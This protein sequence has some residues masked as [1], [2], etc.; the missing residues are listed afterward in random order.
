MVFQSGQT[1]KTHL[2]FISFSTIINGLSGSLHKGKEHVWWAIETCGMQACRAIYGASVARALL[3]L[4][5]HAGAFGA[6][7]TLGDPAGLRS[8]SGDFG[9]PGLA[10]RAGSGGAGADGSVP[11]GEGVSAADTTSAPGAPDVGA[12]SAH[13]DGCSTDEGP[14]FMAKVCA[15]MHLSKQLCPTTSVKGAVGSRPTGISTLVLS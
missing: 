2:L 4:A 15:Q 1:T 13:G 5:V 3:P 14:Q 12:S 7:Q 6:S 8:A 9:P 10:A 11:D